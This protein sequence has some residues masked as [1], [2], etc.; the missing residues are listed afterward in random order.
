MG[1]FREARKRQ[2]NIL[3]GLDIGTSKI[4]VIIGEMRTPAELQILGVGLSRSEGLRQ[5]VVINLDQAV[6]SIRQ[7]VDE[8][9]LTAGLEVHD[10][11]VGIAGDHIRS[12]NSR[13][14]V[15][16]SRS[17]REISEQDVQ[18]VIDA[19]KA[20]ALP[21]DREL[22]HVL[23]QE[24]IVDNQGG[25]KNPVGISGTRLE[26]EI[27]IVTGAV[28]SAQ[29]INRSVEKAGLKVTGMVLEPLAS[30]YAVLDQNEK[31][32]G[33]A[34][35][36]LGAGTTDIAL[37]YD[38]AIRHTAVITMGGQNVTNDIALGLR[39]P[40]AQAEELKKKY[41]SCHKNA[42]GELKSIEVPG[43][44]GHPTRDVSS[45]LLLSIIQPRMEE[46]FSLAAKEMKRS[47]YG[48]LMGAGVVLTGGGAL[49]GGAVDLAEEIFGHP[50][51]IGA[52][53]GMTGLA[54]S[55]SSP[56]FAT[57][58]GLVLCGNDKELLGERVFG[59]GESHLFSTV[60]QWMRHFVKDF[61]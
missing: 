16:V 11:I 9:Q 19:A 6:H 27:H 38:G 61:F 32:L 20:I 60:L 29:N 17:D 33:V 28:T 22:L 47:E 53:R 23:P 25:I 15:G 58:V 14:V 12:V 7:A 37:F 39:T 44:G 46:I 50:T 52:P 41:G 18:R 54:D 35:V 1:D 26:A 30:S 43:I 45:S 55:A 51:R 34:L 24:F 8:A 59:H 21:I 40:L 3:V 48:D 56:I 13:G 49:L 57:G 4:G 5:G 42:A 36:D 10:V 31:D 2:E